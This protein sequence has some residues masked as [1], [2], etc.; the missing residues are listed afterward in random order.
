[1]VVTYS[2]V[3]IAEFAGKDWEKPRRTS[4]RICHLSSLWIWFTGSCWPVRLIAHSCIGQ[5]STGTTSIPKAWRAIRY[6][7]Q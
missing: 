2:K 4:V 3:L 5:I 6:Q 7:V 1:V